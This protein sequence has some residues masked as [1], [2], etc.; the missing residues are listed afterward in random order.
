MLCKGPHPDPSLFFFRL[1]WQ[2]SLVQHLSLLAFWPLWPL[3]LP[4]PVSHPIRYW[5]CVGGLSPYW[6]ILLGLHVLSAKLPW[7]ST[8][9]SWPRVVCAAIVLPLAMPSVP[10]WGAWLS[11]EVAPAASPGW[12]LLFLSLVR[13]GIYWYQIHQCAVYMSLLA[14]CYLTEGDFTLSSKLL[15]SMY[16]WQQ[17]RV[18]KGF[19]FPKVSNSH[20]K[21]VTCVLDI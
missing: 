4:S 9:L 5:Q 15:L 21:S 6:I 14:T 2:A 19:R 17:N 12:P 7:N 20:V 18:Y 3:C 11:A 16:K 1:D 10:G 8:S 13:T